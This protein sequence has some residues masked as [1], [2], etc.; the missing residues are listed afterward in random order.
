MAMAWNLAGE[1]G[2]RPMNKRDLNK[3]DHL[4]RLMDS[5]NQWDRIK[6]R[7]KWRKWSQKFTKE[8]L[9][10]AWLKIKDKE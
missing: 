3:F 1:H 2:G 6:G 9:D 4:V 10:E 5:P 8:Q 7:L